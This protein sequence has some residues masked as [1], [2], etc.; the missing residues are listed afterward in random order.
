MKR[1]YLTSSQRYLTFKKNGGLILAVV[2]DSRLRYTTQS[3]AIFTARSDR[4]AV[5]Y[6]YTVR[7]EGCGLCHVEDIYR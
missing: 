7:Q 3:V 4:I 1:C 6:R 5:L 2:V